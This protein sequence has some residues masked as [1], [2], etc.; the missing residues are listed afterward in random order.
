MTRNGS[1]NPKGTGT[2]TEAKTE[3][4][5]AKRKDTKIKRGPGYHIVIEQQMGKQAEKVRMQTR[6]RT[7]KRK[8]NERRINIEKGRRTERGTTKTGTTLTEQKAKGEICRL[9]QHHI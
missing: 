1:K 5:K 3:T 7:M 4:G 2:E 6:N 9:L 8:R